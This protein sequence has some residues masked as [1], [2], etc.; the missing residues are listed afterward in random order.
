MLPSSS[1]KVMIKSARWLGLG[2]LLAALPFSLGASIVTVDFSLILNS[3]PGS[4]SFSYDSTKVG[5]DFYGQYANAA[6]GLDSFELDYNGKTYT[7]S[8]ALPTLP[9]V[10][11]PGNTY[12]GSVPPGDFSFLAA[13]IIPGSVSGSNEDVIGL[14]RQL[15]A[16]EFDNVVSPNIST[17][18]AKS[19][20]PSSL[21]LD[22]CPLSEPG[23]VKSCPDLVVSTGSITGESVVPEPAALPLAAVGLAGLWFARRRKVAQ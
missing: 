11:L 17:E 5:T 12:E 2:A 14:G 3:I 15:S 1:I 19:G 9:I 21:T 7:M 23:N 16:F 4:G 13:W 8:Q 10:F 22:A 20:D 18:E 6:N